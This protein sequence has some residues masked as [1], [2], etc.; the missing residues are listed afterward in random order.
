MPI[1]TQNK[2]NVNQDILNTYMME[3]PRLVA[4]YT[5]LV[6]ENPDGAIRALCDKERRLR[7]CQ[8][9]RQEGWDLYNQAAD[10]VTSKYRSQYPEVFEI[11]ERA[12]AKSRLPKEERTKRILKD[13][14]TTLTGMGI[15]MKEA[16]KNEMSHLKKADGI[17]TS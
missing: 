8:Q 5:R 17:K 15:D 6:E 7:D 3:N 12:F 16:I 4:S 2:T 9:Q 11:H 10:N 1:H 14:R 13:V